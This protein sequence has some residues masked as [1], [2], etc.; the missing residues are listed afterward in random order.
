[1]KRLAVLV[2]AIALALA[3][4]VLA[5]ESVTATGA[6]ERLDITSYQYGTH[7]VHDEASGA[8]YVLSSDV[9]DLDAYTGQRVTV[10]STLV[11]GYEYGQVEGG[12]PLVDVTWVEPAPL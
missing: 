2:V 11:P 10:Y 4:P 3:A 1:M 8:L 6:M 12:L 5:Q 7:A 9:V